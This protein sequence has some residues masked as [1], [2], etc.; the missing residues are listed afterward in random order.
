LLGNLKNLQFLS[1]GENNLLYVPQEIGLLGKLES[2]YINDNLELQNLPFE[3]TQC[4]Q[5]QIMS[6]ES[7]PLNE[8]PGDIVNGGPALIMQYLKLAQDGWGTG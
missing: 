4:S 8:I 3:L 6:I 7:C 2:L 1:A 5:L